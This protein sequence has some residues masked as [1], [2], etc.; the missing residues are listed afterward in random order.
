MEKRWRPEQ[1]SRRKKRKLDEAGVFG[2]APSRDGNHIQITSERG[3][4]FASGM[5]QI[6]RFLAQRG[7]TVRFQLLTSVVCFMEHTRRSSTSLRN[8]LELRTIADCL[9]TLLAGDF[10]HWATCSCTFSELCK[11]PPSRQLEF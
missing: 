6:K 4:L 11:R 5:Q 1:R 3:E 9:D 10:P 7:G 8:S 2:L